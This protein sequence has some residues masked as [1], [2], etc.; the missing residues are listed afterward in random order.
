MRKTNRNLHTVVA[1]FAISPLIV[2]AT[3]SSE[4]ANAQQSAS[5]ATHTPNATPRR[6]VCAYYNSKTTAGVAREVGRH[7]LGHRLGSGI[8]MQLDLA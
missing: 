4:S 6:A 2:A 5:A 7:G 3:F 8:R 1:R